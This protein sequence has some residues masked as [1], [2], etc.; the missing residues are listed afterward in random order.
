[1]KKTLLKNIA[2]VVFGLAV[3]YGLSF[4]SAAFDTPAAAAPGANIDVP[5]HMGPNQVKDG[6]LSVGSFA[7]MQDASFKQQTFIDSTIYGGA[8][9]YGP[10]SPVYFGDMSISPA[11]LRVNGDVRVAGALQ[12]D[13]VKNS[14]NESLCADSNGKM[15]PCGAPVPPPSSQVTLTPSIM[16]QGYNTLKY[17]VTSSETLWNT[18]NVYVS[19]SYNG[20]FEGGYAI[21]PDENCWNPG[22]Y[23]FM[24]P[25]SAGNSSVAYD[26]TKPCPGKQVEITIY[27]YYPQMTTSGKNIILNGSVVNYW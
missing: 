7:D 10:G 12:S 25:L 2:Y 19:V 6:G 13:S 3:A 11:H 4:A 16:A 24:L 27:S 18:V 8:P 5:L 17:T 20:N 22:D 26:V 21:Q 1:M 14:Q 15:Y 9:W 23:S